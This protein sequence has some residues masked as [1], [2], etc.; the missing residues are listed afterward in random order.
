MKTGQT[1][2]AELQGAYR[3]ATHGGVYKEGEQNFISKVITDNPTAFFNKVRVLPQLKALSQENQARV[4]QLVKS[5]GFSGYQG[6]AASQPQ[7]KVYNGVKY[8]RGPNGEAVP[9]Q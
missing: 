3:Q 1:L 2:A 7:Y 9:V 8:M 5:K 6:T 4:D